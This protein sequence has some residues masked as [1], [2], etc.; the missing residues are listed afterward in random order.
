[1]KHDSPEQKKTAYQIPLN[2]WD[3]WKQSWTWPRQWQVNKQDSGK[4]KCQGPAPLKDEA[5]RWRHMNG[6]VFSIPPHARA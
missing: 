6:F 2:Q 1:M 4:G 3:S 5:V